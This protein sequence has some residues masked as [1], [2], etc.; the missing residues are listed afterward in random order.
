MA[1]AVLTSKG[2]TTIPKEVRDLLGLHTGDQLEFIVRDKDE[3]VLRPATM[4]L[5]ALKGILRREGRPPISLEAMNTAIRR[6]FRQGA[7]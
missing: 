7:K 6:R 4:Q 3:V 1:T 2:Q 5:T